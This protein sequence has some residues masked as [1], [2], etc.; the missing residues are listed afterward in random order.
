MTPLVRSLPATIP[1]VAPEALERVRGKPFDARL[2]A[3][4]SA[5]GISPEAERCLQAAL[6]GGGC[7]RYPDPEHHELRTV[8][9]SRH[10]VSIDEIVVD[11]G[12]DSLLGVAVRV[13]VAPGDVAVTSAGAYPTFNYHVSGVGG[14]LCT[15]PYRELHED[16]RALLAAAAE[17]R[18]RMVYVS[19]PDNPMGTMLERDIVSASIE[20]LPA[21]CV[22]A[23]D[24]AYADFVD[25]SLLPPLDTDNAQVIRFRTFSKAYGLAGLRIGYAIAHRDLIT[26]MN[27]IRN[28]FGVGRLSQIAAL[29]SLHDVGF[30]ERVIDRVEEG[31]QQIHALA[32]DLELPSVGSFTNFVAVDLG[33]A[34][35]ANRIQQ[36]LGESGVFV[37]KPQ[38]AGLD[39]FLRVGVGTADEY[40]L[41]NRALRGALKQRGVF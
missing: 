19:N 7:N 39:S 36:A 18:A 10:G 20:Q 40:A 28:H 11:A 14:D 34:K 24:E 27:K 23:L 38:A 25:E 12:I 1:F 5:F 2:G 4:E 9:A 26:G 8:L 33:D 17:H 22:L 37:R 15:V 31:R 3:N 35:H 6:S 29:A 32:M 41:L 16:T 13:L 21:G 30:L